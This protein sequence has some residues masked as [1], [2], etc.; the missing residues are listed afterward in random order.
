MITTDTGRKTN[1]YKTTY[2]F[3]LFV[4][5][6]I[7]PGRISELEVHE[8]PALM[9]RGLQE[10]S[11]V[12]GDELGILQDRHFGSRTNSNPFTFRTRAVLEGFVVL[13][14]WLNQPTVGQSCGHHH[15]DSVCTSGVV[16]GK[17]GIVWG[18]R[19]KYLVCVIQEAKEA[20][21]Y[22]SLQYHM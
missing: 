15:R 17:A 12:P 2:I 8:D 4:C 10:Q 21:K 7:L 6:K 16:T 3:C 5:F 20:F 1:T 22:V 11:L 9:R 18:M 14:S 13:L 19:R